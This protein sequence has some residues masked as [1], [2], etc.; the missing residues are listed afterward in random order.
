MDADKKVLFRE[1]FD[2]DA[3]EYDQSPRYVW[4][5]STYPFIVVEALKR[6]RQSSFQ[7]WKAKTVG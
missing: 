1:R 7:T 6:N 5:R 4:A 2:R 3:S